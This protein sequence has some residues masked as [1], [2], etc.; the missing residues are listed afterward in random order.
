MMTIK[1]K[2]VVAAGS[3]GRVASERR[4]LRR[5]HG[6]CGGSMAADAGAVQR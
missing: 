5:K 4:Q 3:G 2:A 1:T 6:G